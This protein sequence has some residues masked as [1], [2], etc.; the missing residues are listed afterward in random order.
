M[1]S[2]DF[3]LGEFIVQPQ[4][5]RLLKTQGTVRIDL[6]PRAMAVLLALVEQSGCVVSSE[7]LVHLVW[8]DR[9]LGD[10]PVYKVILKL[11]RALG[12]EAREPRYIETIPRK[13]YRLLVAPAPVGDGSPARSGAGLAGSTPETD[14]ARRALPRPLA[15]IGA[16]LGLLGA[17]ALL[18][19]A[20]GSS[21]RAP[22]SCESPAAAGASMQSLRPVPGVDARD[23]SGSAMIDVG[24][25][26][27]LRVQPGQHG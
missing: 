22:D 18:T 5:D 12:D 9:P 7:E 17:A 14:R 10:N 11:R 23:V 4:A 8:H 24:F 15:R 27:R 13:G 25:L 21:G 3:R 20:G 19:S 2:T 6:E 1:V 16:T 26:N